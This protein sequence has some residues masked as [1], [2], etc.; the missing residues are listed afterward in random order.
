MNRRNVLV[1]LGAVAILTGIVFGT[2]AF[3][4]V[5]ADRT[6]T[7]EF[8]DDENA[9]LGLNETSQNPEYVSFVSGGAGQQVVQINLDNSSAAGDGLNDDAVTLIDPVL[10]V[11]N[12]GTQPV[13]VSFDGTATTEGIALT[14]TNDPALN[15]LGVGQ[16]EQVGIEVAVG[17]AP[18]TVNGGT[19][20]ASQDNSDLTL[21]IEADAR[22]TP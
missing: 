2:G 9:F 3:T 7:V 15:S 4:Q 12:Q 17:N 5:E 11:T 14:G 1:A 22:T 18:R 21:V 16:T 20:N 19:L 10:N 13:N 6:V 8:A